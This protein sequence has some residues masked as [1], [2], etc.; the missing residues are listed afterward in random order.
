MCF[1]FFSMDSACVSCERKVRFEDE[2]NSSIT[3]PIVVMTNSTPLPSD[4]P[5]PK[6]PK[7]EDKKQRRFSFSRSSSSENSKTDEKTKKKSSETPSKNITES[8]SES[9][10]S[11]L[12]NNIDGLTSEDPLPKIMAELS[13]TYPSPII[14]CLEELTNRDFH[15]NHNKENMEL[16]IAESVDIHSQMNNPSLITFSKEPSDSPLIREPVLSVEPNTVNW[17][18]IDP[19]DA[20]HKLSLIDLCLFQKVSCS[21]IIKHMKNQRDSPKPISILGDQ[22][23]RTANLISFQIVTAKTE[24]ERKILISKFLLIGRFLFA[25]HNFNGT[26]QIVMAFTNTAVRRLLSEKETSNNIWKTI[27]S[28]AKPEKNFQSYRTLLMSNPTCIPVFS[29]ILNDVLHGYET[30]RLA[31]QEQ[32]KQAMA[33]TLCGIAET[34]M[35]FERCR[36][37]PTPNSITEH[38]NDPI[39]KSC[40]EFQ[41]IDDEVLD[42]FSSL[43]KEWILPIKLESTE[44]KDW[45]PWYFA[46]L[47]RVNGCQD[48]IESIF[49][50]KIYSGMDIIKYMGN[51][52]QREKLAELGMNEDMI[53]TIMSASF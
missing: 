12:V 32:N 26:M 25:T 21:D 30:F 6:T 36:T 18:E 48:Y 4:N 27:S 40:L 43:R 13:Q 28:I 22:F 45:T 7:R 50:R 44:L 9:V 39:V 46:S 35:V 11:S 53:N 14:L 1:I 5:L 3:T 19:K 10:S 42:V 2:I 29:L 17:H 41:H 34:L 20:A 37:L 38:L 49:N 24:E 15:H 51:S 31:D 8:D 52:N 33:K 16:A 47:L 23:T